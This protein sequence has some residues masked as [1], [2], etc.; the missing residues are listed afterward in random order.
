MMT[1]AHP[2]VLLL[3]VLVPAIPFWRRWRHRALSPAVRFS[4]AM[5]VRDLP[6]T[7]RQRLR[8]LLTALRMI[9]L[10]C[11]IVALARPQHGVGETRVTAD[12]VAIEIVVDRSSSMAQAMRY[13]GEEIARIDV[14]KRVFTDFVKGREDAGLEGRPTDL[15]GLVTFARFAETVCPLVRVHDT[16]VELAGSIELARPRL[17]DGTAIGEGL[18]LAAARLKTAEEELLR[19]NRGVTDPEFEIKSKIVILLTDGAENS[20]DITAE[21]AARLCV[22]WGIKVYAI[23][24]GG[25]T[26]PGQRDLFRFTMD[27]FRDDV[28]KEIASITGGK[29]WAATSGEALRGIYAEIDQL[30]TTKI[31]STE[32]TSYH[33]AFTTWAWVAGLALCLELALGATVLRRIP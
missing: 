19:R 27:E 3:L 6:M 32:Y 29:Y 26:I 13:D 28:L 12:G 5:L 15:I 21:Q 25:T 31:E 10:A 1:F 33:E 16:L 2:A 11:L 9:G 7:L 14:L 8:W 24:I 30:E 18:A 4:S 23:G 20:G 22:D 17:D